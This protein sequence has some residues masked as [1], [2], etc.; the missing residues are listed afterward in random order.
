MADQAA[1]QD[2]YKNSSMSDFFFSEC[3][4]LFVVFTLQK[5]KD[6]P[7]TKKITSLTPIPKNPSG[8]SSGRQKGFS[9]ARECGQRREVAD[10]A[11]GKSSPSWGAPPQLHI[12]PHGK[13]EGTDAWVRVCG[14][15]EG[16][17]NSSCSG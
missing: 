9:P 2:Q 5:D 7:Q 11:G 15:R 17:R 1:Q 6:L 14:D 13:Q 8:F 10:E 3:S 4:S 16:L 12:K